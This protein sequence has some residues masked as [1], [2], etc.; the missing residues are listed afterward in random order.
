MRTRTRLRKKA[1]SK[2]YADFA[3]VYDRLMADVDYDTWA[4]HYRQLLSQ[5]GVKDNA[6]VLEAACGTG[7]LTIRLA[8]DFRVLPSDMSEEML[9]I[10]AAKARANGLSL[11]FLK[12]DMRA[13]KA[14]RLADAI[15]CGCDGVNYLLDDHSLKAF[16]SSAHAALKPGGV[17]AFDV[18]N[19]D[20]LSRVLGNAPQI[21]REEDICYIWENAFDS[22]TNLLHLSLSIFVKDKAVRYQR[23]EE[24][25]TQRAYTQDVLQAALTEA[26]FGNI[27]CFGN[28][29]LSKPAKNAQRLHFTAI[30]E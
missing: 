17:L 4:A 16:F 8:R 27:Q 3:A 13:L 2:M 12:Q 21:L 7:N 1:K 22:K 10:A 19:Y 11:T 14:H 9:T 20:K 23:I 6:L 30:K 26:G 15:V 18:S 25:Q 28:F 5:N 29:T 24:E